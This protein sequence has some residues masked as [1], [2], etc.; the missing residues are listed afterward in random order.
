[1]AAANLVILVGRLTRDPESHVFSSGGKV[2]SFGLAISERKK[3]HQTG[4]YEDA[5]VFVDVKAFNNQHRTLADTCEQYLRKGQQ[6]YL[7]GKLSLEQ[8]TDKEGNRRSKTLVIANDMQ[9]LEKRREGE[10]VAPRP[11]ESTSY[12]TPKAKTMA[13]AAVEPS[14]DDDDTSIPF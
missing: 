14:G 6:I 3:N 12:T 7:Q 2:V 1:M 8:W 9:F 11:V 10:E 4:Q 5:P 13:K